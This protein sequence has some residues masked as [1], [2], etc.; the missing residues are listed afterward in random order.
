MRKLLNFL[1]SHGHWLLLLFVEGVAFTFL[2]NGSAYHRYLNMLFSNQFIGSVHEVSGLV[3]SYIGLREK[4]RV[5]TEQ[6]A[7]LE[8]MYLQLRRKVEYAE[9]DSVR[10]FTYVAD[11]TEVIPHYHF[12]TA[13]V[14]S[15]SINKNRN[16]IIIDKGSQAGIRRDMGVVSAAGVVGIVAYVSKDYSVVIPLINPT[17]K[18]SCKLLRTG[19]F[20][21]ISW[22]GAN[23]EDRIAYLSDLPSHVTLHKGDTIVTSGFSSIYPANIYVGRVGQLETSA[24]GMMRSHSAVPVVLGAHFATL[25]YVYVV[26]FSNALEKKAL[27]SIQQVYNR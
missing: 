22:G 27:D 4:N 9:A 10:P 19:H 13:R 23:P 26:S 1:S 2:F 21:Y 8:Q 20:G 5:L 15:A 6:N 25:D 24:D 18:L 3:N 11:S 14:V 17:L 7:Q 16:L 12:I